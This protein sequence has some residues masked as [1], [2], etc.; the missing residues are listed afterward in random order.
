MKQAR[1]I[2]EKKRIIAAALG[3]AALVMAGGVAAQA[4][5]SK[6]VTVLSTFQLG[7]APEV[8]LRLIADDITKRTGKNFIL[9]SR[10]GGG[11]AVGLSLLNRAEPDGHT[12]GYTFTGALLVNPYTTKDLGW[13]PTSFAPIG[14]IFNSP[15][16]IVGDPNF[17]GKTMA[18][19]IRMAKEKPNSVSIAIGGSGNKIGLAQIENATGAKFLWVPVSNQVR[20]NVMGGHV[21]LGIETPSSVKSLIDDGKLTAVGIGSLKRFDYVP[22][23]QPIAELV[24]GFE[25]GFWFGFLAPKGTPADRLGW[26]N[27][28]INTS[29]NLPAIQAKMKELALDS[30]TETPQQFDAYLRKTG[31]EFGDIIK[32]NNIN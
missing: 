25:N 12:L 30:I 2:T 7:G 9:E 32:R 15:I 10:A 16:I 24:P 1:R 14:R 6:N 8:P 20:A 17:P 4:F 11:G 19:V 26:L 23:V 21:N 29:L 18:D 5:P 31:P 3:L 27:M 22:N 13:D 28:E